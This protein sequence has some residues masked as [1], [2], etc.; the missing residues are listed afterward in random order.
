[1]CGRHGLP[2]W[3]RIHE[4]CD[5]AHERGLKVHMDGARIFNAAAALGMPVR[6]IAAPADTVMFCLSKGA[7][8]A[9]RLDAGRA[10]RR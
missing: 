7:G 9:G 5:G 8:R 3:R 10:G 4:I 2:A 6:E 1:M